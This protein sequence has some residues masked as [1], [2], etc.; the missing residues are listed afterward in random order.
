MISSFNRLNRGRKNSP[1]VCSGSRIV[2]TAWLSY[3]WTRS[4]AWMHICNGSTARYK[5]WKRFEEVMNDWCVCNNLVDDDRH[6]LPIVIVLSC[7]KHV[8]LRH[9]L[10]FTYIR[11]ATVRE[12]ISKF[13]FLG[14]WFFVPLNRLLSIIFCLMSFESFVFSLHTFRF[15]NDLYEGKSKHKTKKKSHQL[16]AAVLKSHVCGQSIT[17]DKWFHV[18]RKYLFLNICLCLQTEV[19]QSSRCSRIEQSLADAEDSGIYQN[20]NETCQIRDVKDILGPLPAVPSGCVGAPKNNNDKNWS[21]RMSALSGIYE[22]ILEPTA[23]F[24]LKSFQML[25]NF[26]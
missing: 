11:G 9:K 5:A 23:R 25:C 17:I 7:R 21:R 3:H 13:T 22:E 4:S 16:T 2:R 14:R 10:V 15:R 19:L 26:H 12:K 20:M 8:N 18:L 24:V 1:M 6:E